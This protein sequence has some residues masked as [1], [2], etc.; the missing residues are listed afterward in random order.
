MLPDRPVLP[1]HDDRVRPYRALP[2]YHPDTIVQHY[3]TPEE[4]APFH[5][6]ALASAGHGRGAG[7]ASSSSNT[8]GDAAG[9]AEHLY[10]Q[11]VAMGLLRR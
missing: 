11:L 4:M 10:A 6:Q 5:E 3:L 8:V 7:G 2:V 9:P 1:T